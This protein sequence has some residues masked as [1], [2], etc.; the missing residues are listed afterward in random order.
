V[1]LPPGSV[2][3]GIYAATDR[4]RGVWK[5]PANAVL[6]DVLE[7]AVKLDRNNW[8]P[9][10]TNRSTPYGLSPGKGILVWSART[11][12]GGDSEWRYVP[13]RRL[14]NMVEASIKESTNWVVFEQND[15]NTRDGVRGMI[16]NR[17]LQKWREGAPVRAKPEEAFY[18]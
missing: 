8:M 15:E 13:V 9:S 1:V 18:V 14:F 7:P 16:E 12:M 5:A 11:L 17:L 2:F 10:S 6:D 4:N 3:A